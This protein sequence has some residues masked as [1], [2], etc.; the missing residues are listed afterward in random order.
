MLRRV[1][2]TTEPEIA[3]RCQVE[4]LGLGS[5]VREAPDSQRS[6]RVAPEEQHAASGLGSVNLH[7]AWGKREALV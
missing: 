1:D 2:L 3:G 5:R 7:Q 4:E 6:R